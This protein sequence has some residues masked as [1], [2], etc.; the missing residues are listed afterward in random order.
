MPWSVQGGRLRAVLPNK[1]QEKALAYFGSESWRDYSVDLDLCGLRGVDKG[2]AIHI[3]GDE[4]IG[5]DLRGDGYDDVL[6]YRGVRKLAEA[7]VANRNGRWHHLRVEARG[8]RYKVYVNGRLKID[9]DDQSNPRPSGRLALAAYTGGAGESEVM[10]DN[11]VVRSL[12]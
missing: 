11:I 8:A 9:Y 3:D 2:V 10:Y 6:L 5:V 4:G 12:R 1:K 7:S